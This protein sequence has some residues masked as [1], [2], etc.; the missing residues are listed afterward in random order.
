MEQLPDQLKN[1]LTRA[2]EQLRA[3][4]IPDNLATRLDQLAAQTS[5][6][7]VVA[8]VGMVKAG[9]SS[10]V[11]ALLK[12]DLAKVGATETTA[13]I[14]YFTYGEPDSSRPIRCHWK[15]G[16]ETLETREF[17]DALQGNDNESLHRALDIDHLEYRL[18]NPYL[19]KITLVDTPGIASVVDEHQNRTAEWVGLRSQLRDRNISKTQDLSAGAD[20]VVYVIGQ[21]PRGTD[22]DF[23]ESFKKKFEQ[24]SSPLNAIGILSKIDQSTDMMDRRHELCGKIAGQLREILN[25]VVPVSSGL[26]RVLDIES[27]SRHAVLADLA[28]VLTRSEDLRDELLASPDY[29]CD[30]QLDGC[31]VSLDERQTI[32]SHFPDWTVLTTTADALA[33]VQYDVSEAVSMLSDIAGFAPLRDLLERRF[34]ERSHILRCSRILSDAISVIG[35]LK[36]EVV[37]HLARQDAN[38]AAKIKRFRDFINNSTGDVTVKKEIQEF[39]SVYGAVG[40]SSTRLEA[41]CSEVERSIGHLDTRLNDDNADIE[42]LQLLDQNRELFSEDEMSTLQRLFGLYGFELE[43]RLRVGIVSVKHV[44]VLDAQFERQAEFDVN[45]IRRRVAEHARSRCGYIRAQILR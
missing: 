1:I 12:E 43:D 21:V 25:T 37:P 22:R 4:R 28:S 3:A 18:P 13:T 30:M 9:K 11:N 7:C 32:L 35:T 20:A 45:P 24:D 27:E 33:K 6:P 19:K 2:S 15:S 16:R 5:E 44:G 26:Q 41:V 39:L 10:F 29:W 8:V 42:C 36:R 31:P 40:G 38:M 34:L 17:L 23:L 14:N